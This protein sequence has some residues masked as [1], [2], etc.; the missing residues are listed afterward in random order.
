MLKKL[1][2]H[3][4]LFCEE[5]IN[6]GYSGVNAYCVAY[7]KENNNYNYNS[8][9]ARASKLLKEHL[10]Q[11]YI[12]KLEEE[13]KHININK[14]EFKTYKQILKSIAKGE[15]DSWSYRKQ[16]DDFILLPTKPTI[17][18]QLKAI[19]ILLK[20]GG[21]YESSLLQLD[22]D[23][24]NATIQRLMSEETIDNLEVIEEQ[25]QEREEY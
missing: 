4:K 23:I 25:E 5:Y 16:G 13:N 21:Y 6:N 11:N 15:F 24:Y 7:G 17:A 18:E 3:H 19:D 20:L 2:E 10:I 12:I 14:N 8:M 22:T 9:K 1:N